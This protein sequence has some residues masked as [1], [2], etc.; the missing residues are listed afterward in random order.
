[1]PARE[2]DVS[3]LVSV[4]IPAFN[5]SRTLDR[6][7]RSVVMQTHRNLEIIVVDDGSSDDTADIARRWASKDPRVHLI[8]KTNGGVASARNHGIRA[9]RGEFVGPID[10]DDLWA[11]TRVAEHLSALQT[12]GPRTALVYSPA[13]L[14]D[15]NDIVFAS[16]TNYGIAG[17]VFFRHLVT[18]LVGN[19]SGIL[20][21]K[22][23]AEEFG[24]YAEWLRERGAEGCEDILLQ[25]L[26]STRYHFAV[27]PRYLIGYRW[28]DSNMSAGVAQMLQSRIYALEYL[29][30]RCTGLLPSAAIRLAI[31]RTRRNLA[32][33]RDRE[34]AAPYVADALTPLLDLPRANWGARRSRSAHLVPFG[35]PP[36]KPERWQGRTFLECSPESTPQPAETSRRNAALLAHGWLD[37]VFGSPEGYACFSEN[38]PRLP[39]IADTLES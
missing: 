28:S 38:S 14:I 9:S 30:S 12:S 36:A 1:M 8:R 13:R 4:V 27:V 18:N 2:G 35:R 24:G 16:S 31:F 32:R 22:A 10:A 21:R 15:R 26:I 11:P 19:G 34:I 5:A 6:T 29:A 23:V 25:L 37:Q 39:Q 20:V 7:I 17:Q 33:E 3:A